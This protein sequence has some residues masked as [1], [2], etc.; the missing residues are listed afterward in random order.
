MDEQFV[1]K[2][3]QNSQ[4]NFPGMNSTS[5]KAQFLDRILP[6]MLEGNAL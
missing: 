5:L 2:L 1:I 3:F 4:L 6:R